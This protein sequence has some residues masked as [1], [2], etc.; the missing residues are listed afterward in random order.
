VNFLNFRGTRRDTH[1]HSWSL[2]IVGEHV[3]TA[4]PDRPTAASQR[5]A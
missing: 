1:E 4:D 5:H 3:D 2:M